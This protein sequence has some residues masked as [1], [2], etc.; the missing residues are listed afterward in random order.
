MQPADDARLHELTGQLA[1]TLLGRALQLVT[2]ESCT[3]GWLAKLCTD[4]PGSSRWFAHGVVTYSNAAK[5]RLLGVSET[6]L[7]QDGAV[8]QSVVEAM[9]SGAKADDPGVVT[10]AISGVAG[11]EGGTAE[12]PVGLVW[13]GWALPGGR[14]M[15]AAEQFAGDRDAVRRQALVLALTGLLSRLGEAPHTG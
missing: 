7:D 14:V 1:E 13:C 2:A 12:K 4:R 5:Q 3:G 11:P 9:A 6:A 15:S 8:S 10:V